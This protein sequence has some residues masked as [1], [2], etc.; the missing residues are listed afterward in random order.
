MNGLKRKVA[1]TARQ[2]LGLEALR[3]QVAELRAEVIAAKSGASPA[4]ANPD[5]TGSKISQLVLLNQYRELRDRGGPLPLL[6]DVEFRAFSQNGEDG[7]LLY[8]FALLGMGDRRCVEICSGDGI[9]CNTANLLINHGWHGLLIDGDESLV[10]QGRAFYTRHPDTFIHPPRFVCDWITR[11]NVNEILEKNQ[12]TGLI[13]L[14]SLDLD[15]VD[16]WIWEAIEAVRPRV[17]IAEVQCL[18]GADRAV[19]VPYAPDFRAQFVDGL[20]IYCGASLP[21]FVKLARRKGYRLV[22]VQRLGFNAVF[23]A[24]GL[25]EE[26]LPEVPIEGCVDL[27]FVRWGREHLL[28]RVQDMD[29]VE[30]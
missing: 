5:S 6:S 3:L 2:A 25:G 17:V 18:W 8:V 24:N 14:L 9:Q 30:V 19:T 16:Y 21:A 13:D 4:P 23:V 26:W 28:P 1:S 11:D 27:P 10:Q 29:W 20:G 7:I 12:F 15:G 22:G